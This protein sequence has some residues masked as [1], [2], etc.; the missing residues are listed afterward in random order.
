MRY[1]NPKH[2]SQTEN[3]VTIATVLKNF[4]KKSTPCH[5]AVYIHILFVA[6]GKYNRGMKKFFYRVI[7]G[8]TLTSIATKFTLPVTLLIKLNALTNDVSAGDLLYVETTDRTLY[9]VKPFDTAELLGQKFGVSPKKILEDNGVPY[10]F[11][12]LIIVI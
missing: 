11:Y 12:G 1:K 6:N 10:L 9:R 7:E 5:I 4:L 8:D 3:T 2:F